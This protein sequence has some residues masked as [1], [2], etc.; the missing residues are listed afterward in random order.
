M[1]L[2]G[3]DISG[4]QAGIDL[5]SVLRNSETHFVIIK[6][7][8]GTSYVNP[9]WR[10]WA[11]IVL[12]EGA[13]LGFYHYSDGGN[14]TAEANF[15]LDTLGEYADKARLVL[16]WEVEGNGQ[17]ESHMRW[18]RPWLE[19]VEK[20][21]GKK[22]WLYVM[23]SRLSEYDWDALWVAQYPNYNPTGYTTPWNEEWYRGLIDSGRLVMRQYSSAGRIGGYPG[24]LDIN[25]FYGTREDWLGE[26]EQR[27]EEDD[28]AAN[29]KAVIMNQ[30]IEDMYREILRR[31][32]DTE[33]LAIQLNAAAESGLA[34]VAVNIAT[35]EE[36]ARFEP[37]QRVVGMYRAFLGRVPENGDVVDEWVITAQREGWATVAAGIHD[38]KEGVQRRERMGL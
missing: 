7:T 24:N 10:E 21:T 8:E 20:R 9:Y 33:G 26:S 36:A 5:R 23:Q 16:D 15:F 19:H 2:N 1:A 38:D 29:I 4:W 3:I 11:D 27:E 14:V 32:A 17:F 22:P 34:A 37:E 31:D 13:L 18:C 6:A 25:K 30:L 35:S 12:G 28:M